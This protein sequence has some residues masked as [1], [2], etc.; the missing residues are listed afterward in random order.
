MVGAYLERREQRG[1]ASSEQHI[2]PQ[3]AVYSRHH[4]RR[5]DQ[6]PHLG[7]VAR[8]DYEYEI[9]GEA[10][11]Q[12]ADQRGPRPEAEEQQRGPHGRHGEKEE[13]GGGVD[14]LHDLSHGALHGLRGVLHVDQIG[15]HAAEHAARPLR[16][17]ARGFAGVDYILAHALVL[18][19]VV[20][21]KR[22]A[23][24]LR[25]EIERGEQEKERDGPDGPQ[26]AAV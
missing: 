20:L 22:F 1:A 14:Y 8:A 21:R 18:R 13:R 17:V 2:T 16:V 5:V 25:R 6:S 3:R 24:E 4:G 11:R 7:D 19:H 26:R 23:R 15:G 10:V 12:R 9:G